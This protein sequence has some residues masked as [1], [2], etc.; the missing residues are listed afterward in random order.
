MVR[1][2]NVLGGFIIPCWA[3]LVVQLKSSAT[4]DLLFGDF[5][6]LLPYVQRRFSF[7]GF[8]GFMGAFTESHIKH[9]QE[10][11]YVSAPNRRR[12]NSKY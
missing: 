11:V 10:S 1:A 7:G 8:K 9:L 12:Q 6:F 5:P 2:C 3:S 4:F